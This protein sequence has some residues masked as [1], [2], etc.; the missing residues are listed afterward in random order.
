MNDLLYTETQGLKGIYIHNTSLKMSNNSA[1]VDITL[2]Y[3]LH[4]NQDA[5]TEFHT[6]SSQITSK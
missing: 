5:E 6:V 1:A 3:R 4:H 2:T